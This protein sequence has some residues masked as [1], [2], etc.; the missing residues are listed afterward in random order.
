MIVDNTPIAG[1]I[2]EWDGE[3]VD[4]DGDIVV[5]G[6]V[7]SDCL[8]PMTYVCPEFVELVE[9]AKPEKAE[10][11]TETVTETKTVTTTSVVLRLTERE[12]ETLKSVC[13]RVGGGT[14]RSEDVNAI[15]A[16]LNSA[17]VK[18]AS[19]DEISGSIYFV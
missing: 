15:Y 17:R 1:R 11:V 6:P 7:V 14:C 18:H 12:A 10:I 16:A 8:S 9:P 13:R 3:T 19:E 5:P 2:F 4:S